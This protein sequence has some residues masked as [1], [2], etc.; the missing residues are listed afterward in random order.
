MH[1]LRTTRAYRVLL[2]GVLVGL[3]ACASSASGHGFSITAA[4]RGKTIHGEVRYQGGIAAPDVSI[5]ATDPDGTRLGQTTTDDDGRFTLPVAYRCEHRLRA[6]TSDGHQQTCVVPVEDLPDD[7]PAP[8]AKPEVSR[9]KPS[10]AHT[11]DHGHAEETVDEQIAD[12]VGKQLAPLHREIA[13][14]KTRLRF[15]DIL[16]AVGYILG[17]MGISFYFLGTRKK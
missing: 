14:L 11:H 10:A 2:P 16:G 9:P 8:G 12:A 15:Q 17:L 5:E 13:E 1:N 3:L 6:T 4:A 7:L